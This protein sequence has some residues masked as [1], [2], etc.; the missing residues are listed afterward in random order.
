MA[1][2]TLAVDKN[3]PTGAASI[4][5]I[6]SRIT[7][8]NSGEVKGYTIEEDAASNRV[9]NDVLFEIQSTGWVLSY[10]GVTYTWKSAE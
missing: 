1:T 3:L 5:Y 8:V 6:T 7:G 2:G 4:T 9:V 10:G